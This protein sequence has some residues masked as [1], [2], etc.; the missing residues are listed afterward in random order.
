M[1]F[2]SIPFNNITKK[3]HLWIRFTVWFYPTV[4]LKENGA[5]LVIH[6]SR[7]D[8]AIEYRDYSIDTAPYQLNK[9]NKFTAEYLT[10]TSLEPTD[11]LHAYVWLR[12]TKDLFI[13]DVH[14]EVFEKK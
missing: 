1:L 2:R 6:F 5:S 11:E 8:K 12:G 13:D 7:D 9:W 14:I 3:D 4:D 10:P